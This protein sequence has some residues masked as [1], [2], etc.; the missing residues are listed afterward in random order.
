MQT[1]A[2]IPSHALPST[3]SQGVAPALII[4][5]PC[6]ANAALPPP[7][8]ASRGCRGAAGFTLI[9]LMIAVAVVGVLSSTAYP[10]FVDQVQRARRSDAIVTVMQLQWAQ[11]RWRSNSTVYGSLAEIGWKIS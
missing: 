6:H 8:Q 5:A 2:S 7:R 4:S 3:P 1:T 11:E 10:T 9:E